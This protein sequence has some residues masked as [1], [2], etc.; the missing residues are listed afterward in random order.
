MARVIEKKIYM[1]YSQIIG[2][3]KGCFNKELRNEIS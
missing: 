2:S 1:R 3:Q